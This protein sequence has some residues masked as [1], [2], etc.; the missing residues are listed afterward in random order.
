M[1][2][3]NKNKNDNSIMIRQSMALMM[4]NVLQSIL[5]SLHPLINPIKMGINVPHTLLYVLHPC[6]NLG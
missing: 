5:N 1:K 2:N 6:P 4:L 3:I